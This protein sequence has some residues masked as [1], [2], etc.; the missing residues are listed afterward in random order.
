M[1]PQ[2]WFQRTFDVCTFTPLA[3]ITGT[4]A[5][6]LPLGTSR[7]GLPIGVQLMGDMGEEA[8][9]LRLA[10]ELEAALPWHERLPTVCA[11]SEGARTAPK[12]VGKADTGAEIDAATTG[13]T[14]AREL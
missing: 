14:A 3:N 5:I 1:T 12:D 13:D 4:S 2:M 6:S 11:G 9:L 7:Q 10:G 8:T